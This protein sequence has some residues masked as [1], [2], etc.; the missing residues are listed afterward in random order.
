MLLLVFVIAVLLSNILVIF[1]GSTPTANKSF[2]VEKLKPI[3]IEEYTCN[4]ILE[5][6]S[7]DSET[8]LVVNQQRGGLG[9]K[10]IST[11]NGIIFALLTKK[12]LLCKHTYIFI[13]GIVITPPLLYNLT[14]SCLKSREYNINGRC[15]CKVL[16]RYL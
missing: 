10:T 7:S 3:S 4:K 12:K 5:V 14:D 15:S 6:T 9:H 11:A 16:I 13:E 1:K 8:K 2:I